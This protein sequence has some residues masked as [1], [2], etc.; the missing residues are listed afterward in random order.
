MSSEVIFDS[1]AEKYDSWYQKPIG[2]YADRVE[3]KCIRS[4][5][6]SEKG[7]VLD[8]GCGTGLYTERL[9][10]TG[11]EVF[12]LDY[13]GKMLKVAEKRAE[14]NFI[15]GDAA[16]LPFRDSSFD[17]IISVT[18]FEFFSDPEKALREMRRVVKNGGFIIIGMLSRG[19]LWSRSRKGKE[20]YKRAHFYTYFEV[21]HLFKPD[22][23]KACLYAPPKAKHL[24][25]WMKTEP[26]L[27]RIFPF[28]GA[29]VAIRVRD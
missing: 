8:L 7:K 22:K 14:G 15:R 9:K 21:K 16:D 12:S 27:S 11:F 18:S 17:G 13:S 29:F 10:K 20:L 28:F 24:G 5:L 4:L 2:R 23:I 3:W 19:N 25:F 1:I 6:P 26:V